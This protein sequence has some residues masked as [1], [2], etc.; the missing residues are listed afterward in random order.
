[1]YSL[2]LWLLRTTIWIGFTRIS[3]TFSKKNSI[4][5]KNTELSNSLLRSVT[6][7][8][9]KETMNCEFCNITLKNFN[10]LRS[11]IQEVHEKRKKF[12]C[13]SCNKAFGQ[14]T[15]L[16]RHIESIHTEKNKSFH[17]IYCD[18]RFDTKRS[19]KRHMTVVH[20]GQKRHECK[21]CGKL[22]VELSNLL[23]HNRIHSG[24]R[25]YR[26]KTCDKSYTQHSSWQK[27]LQVMKSSRG[28]PLTGVSSTYMWSFFAKIENI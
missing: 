9:S 20:I 19:V 25:P 21:I 22:F 17:C 23:V 5:W 3:R 12:K 6:N 10:T 27:V 4:R 8:H 13:I 28:F 7:S 15:T 16:K 1:M 18:E 11:H 24:E 14:Q 2:V 26:C